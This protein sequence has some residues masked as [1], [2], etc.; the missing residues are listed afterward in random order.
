MSGIR[1]SGAIAAI[2]I[3]AAACASKSNAPPEP[4]FQRGGTLRVALPAMVGD[5]A[6]ERFLDP[7]F[8]FEADV[9]EFA[10]CCL[11]RTLMT[12]GR[13]PTYESGTPRPPV[14]AQRLPTVS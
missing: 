9:F 4:T 11:L 13:H 5:P 12:A 3:L 6:S 14:L 2:L 7:Q 1:R 8:S 10:R